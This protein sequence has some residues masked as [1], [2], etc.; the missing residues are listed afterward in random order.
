M[1]PVIKNQPKTQIKEINGR[2]VK[3]IEKWASVYFVRFVTGRPTFVS[4]KDLDQKQELDL[5]T[6][7]T[8]LEKQLPNYNISFVEEEHGVKIGAFSLQ[9]MPGNIVFRLKET[10]VRN[11]TDT[12][13][14]NQFSSEQVYEKFNLKFKAFAI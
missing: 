1:K 7:K 9:N 14:S 10:D 3:S 8:F 11:V 6:I 4:F 13:K 12:I 2:E 5:D